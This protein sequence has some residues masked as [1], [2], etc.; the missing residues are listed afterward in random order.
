MKK[1]LRFVLCLLASFVFAYLC[2]GDLT[3]AM[4]PARAVGLFVTFLAFMTALLFLAL[5]AYL[6]LRTRVGEL[7]ARVDALEKEASTTDGE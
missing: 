1:F 5:E 7:E 2:V 3:G 6:S 4:E